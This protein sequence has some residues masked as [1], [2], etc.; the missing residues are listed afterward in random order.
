M[1]YKRKKT[2]WKRS[3][4]GM[5]KAVMLGVFFIWT[6]FPLYW[7]FITSFKTRQEIY[8]PVTLWPQNFVLTNYIDAFKTSHFGVYI[9]NSFYVSIVSSIIIII[10][11]LL[12]GYALAR[13][14]F[15]GKKLV[16][17][18]FLVSQMIPLVVAI[19][20]MYVIYG[21]L[22]LIDNL[23]CLI[24]SYTVA[25][26]PF[27][28]ITMSSFYAGISP[29]LEEAAM[30]DGCSRRQ[31]VIRV[32]LPLLA[33]GLVAVFVFAF[34]GCWN[35]LYYA[36]M[37]INSEENRTI[38]V[39]LMSFIQKFDVNWGS[40]TASA[41]VTLIPVVIMFSAVQKHIVAGMT[42]GAVKE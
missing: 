29:S 21:K 24:I 11:S 18:I 41:T 26:V 17:M 27:C 32:I 40:I 28:L 4:T 14:N 33:P 13:Y 2:N 8:G 16:M 31:A 37:M 34:T 1:K 42:S 30:I 39:G 5:L 10:V 22:K 7:M 3:L 12:G 38:P 35:E 9:G 36:I 25:N 19:I 6:V 15:K 20:P 23:S